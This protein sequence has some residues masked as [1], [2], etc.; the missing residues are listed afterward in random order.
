MRS[1]AGAAAT[2]GSTPRTRQD[3]QG[4]D[5]TANV[6]SPY[7]GAPPA[8]HT[9][10]RVLVGLLGLAVAAVGIALLFHPVSAAHA[11]AVLVGLGFVLAG[12]LETAVG[13]NSG[14]RTVTV[15]LGAVLV[16]AG[17]LA[18]AWPELTLGTLALITGLALILHGIA[19]IALAVM[20]RAEFPGWGWLALAGGV[21][22]LIGVLAIAWPQVTVFVLCIVLGVQV[23]LFGLVLLAVAF[24]GTG[25]GAAGR[26]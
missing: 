2:L 14:H 7:A 1:P 3:R 9:G 26:S 5:M 12:L 17:V 19:R 11:L 8:R 23:A 22:V 15:A 25:A 21:N 10:T 13:W 20:A 4:S 16:L 18:A 6:S 24:T